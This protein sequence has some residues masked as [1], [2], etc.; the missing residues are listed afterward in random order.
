MNRYTDI[1]RDRRRDVQMYR[2]TDK[3]SHIDQ[4]A[5]REVDMQVIK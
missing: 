4:Q 3:Q 2:W 5:D 1:Q